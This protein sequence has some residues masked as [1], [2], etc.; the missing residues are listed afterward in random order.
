VHDTSDLENHFDQLL[1]RAIRGELNPGERA[2]VDQHVAECA[3]CAAALDG[4]D[5]FRPAMAPGKQDDA[6]NHA[7][8]AK[9]LVRLHESETFG[10]A[11]R[12]WLTLRSAT[13]L[14]VVATLAIGFALRLAPRPQ[15]PVVAPVISLQ[16]LILDDGS[17]I[18]PVDGRTDVQLVEQTPARATVRLRSGSAQ[19]RVSHDG[20]R[21]FRVDTG[22]I[23][24]EDIGTAFLVGH[25]AGD[26]VRVAVSEGKVAVL[27][28]ANGW[29]VE[30]G[31]GE[32]RV[33]STATEFVE[34]VKEAPLVPASS[35]SA[36]AT[37]AES[38]ARSVDEPAELLLAADLARRSRKPQE[39]IVPLRRLVERFPKDPRAASAAF[40][41]GWVLL[42]DL[43]RPREAASA[44]ASAERNAPRRGLAE[45]A[46]ARVAESWQ[47]AGDTRR[48][49]EAARHYAKVY[50]SGRYITLMRSMIGEN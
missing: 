6:L 28:H 20:R 39:A 31:A 3:D 8:V 13:A 36:D 7:A 12:R 41:L 45:D 49:T 29:R 32:E 30:L 15:H 26:K 22:P 33:F 35:A 37:R 21:L 27:H 40:T 38:R 43:G 24:I 34:P 50:P 10:E 4:A 2:Q 42:T 47:K 5:V 25:E 48:A 16:P 23:Q 17:E 11:L 9:A 46:A 44:F 14:V 19:F 1:K 18:T